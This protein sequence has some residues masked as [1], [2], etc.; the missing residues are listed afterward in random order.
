MTEVDVSDAGKADT[1]SE[2]AE[3]KGDNQNNESEH[4]EESGNNDSNDNGDSGGTGLSVQEVKPVTIKSRLMKYKNHLMAGV[5][6]LVLGVCVLLLSQRV[7]PEEKFRQAETHYS[8]GEYGQAVALFTELAQ[9]G[10]APSQ[11]YL[12]KCNETGQG[13]EANAAAA[14]EW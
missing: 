14:F 6:V 12:G 10:H 11:W 5:A 2:S 13:I 3:N 8:A 7:T 4:Q 9:V 1:K